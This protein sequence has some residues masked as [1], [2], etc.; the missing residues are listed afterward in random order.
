MVRTLKHIFALETGDRVHRLGLEPSSGTQGSSSDSLGRRNL[1][2]VMNVGFAQMKK[3][4][5]SPQFL[6]VR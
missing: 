5:Q 4:F 6:S 3:K 2:I 1:N